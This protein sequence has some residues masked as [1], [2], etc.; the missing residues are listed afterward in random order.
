MTR[1]QHFPVEGQV[2]RLYPSL[3]TEVQAGALRRTPHR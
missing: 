1:M 3:Y 2:A